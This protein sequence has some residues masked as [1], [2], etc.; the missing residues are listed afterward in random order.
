VLATILTLL[1]FI[2]PRAVA[3]QEVSKNVTGDKAEI[4]IA[5]KV[6]DL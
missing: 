3:A 2:W 5:A 4:A 6:A 1:F